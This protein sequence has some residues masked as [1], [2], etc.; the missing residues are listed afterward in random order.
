MMSKQPLF[1]EEV[2]TA[3]RQLTTDESVSCGQVTWTLTFRLNK[4][5]CVC[6]SSKSHASVSQAI[7]RT[8]LPISLDMD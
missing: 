5:Q 8:H 4:S 7:M 2:F 6:C 1:N 3:L